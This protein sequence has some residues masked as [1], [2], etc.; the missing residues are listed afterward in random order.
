MLEKIKACIDLCC[1]IDLFPPPRVQL[2]AL[3]VDDNPTWS[4]V[5]EN[6]VKTL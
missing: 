5:R 2:K 1:E 4:A 3:V 6:K